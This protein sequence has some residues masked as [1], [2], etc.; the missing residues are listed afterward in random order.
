MEMNKKQLLEII[1]G[2][3]TQETEFKESFPRDLP[4]LMAGFSNTNGGVI[5]IGITSKKSIIGVKGDLDKLQQKISEAAQEV[6]PRVLPEIRV[7]NFNGKKVISITID[8]AVGD[9]CTFKGVFYI[10]SGSTTKRLEGGHEIESLL[11]SKSII[12]FDE[13]FSNAGTKDLDTERIREY[14]KT[15][16]KE[17]F[18]KKNSVEQFLLSSELAA[19]NGGLKIRNAAALFFSKEPEKFFPQIEI[20]LALFAGTKPIKIISHKLIQSDP[21]SSIEMSMAFIEKN[22]SKSIKITGKPKRQEKPEYP[23]EVIRE[24]II[25]AVAHR[26]YFS[27]DSIQIYIFDDRIE[28]TSPGSLPRGLPRKLFGSL[29][30]RRNPIIYRLL[31]DHDYIE[32]LGSGVP[33]MIN[34]MRKNGMKDP[35]FQIDHERIFRVVLHNEKGK[36]KPIEEYADLNQRQKKCIEFLEKHKTIKTSKYQELNGVSSGTAIADINELMKFGYIKKIG[37]YRG[38]Y[39]VLNKAENQTRL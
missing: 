36:Q 2:G 1:E 14:L 20:K 29:S 27:K 8:K 18:L 3:E 6:S 24:S 19:R 39:Y 9:A 7:H 25:N 4:K 15:R 26:D 21:A 5:V 10:R 28:I 31:R 33:R 23:V 13:T 35:D 32:G 30:I 34:A 17:S 38:A 16:N 11:T 37:A 22:L 12:C